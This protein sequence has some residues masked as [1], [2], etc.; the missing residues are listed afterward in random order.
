MRRFRTRLKPTRGFQYFAGRAVRLTHTDLQIFFPDLPAAFDGYRILQLSDLHLDHIDETAAAAARVIAGIE[1]D[2][3]VI[4]GDFRDSAR[5]PLDDVMAQLDRVVSATRAVDGVLGVLGNHDSVAMVEPIEALGVRLLLNETIDLYRG[6]ERI[7]V[8]GLDDVHMF[9]TSAA[10]EVLASVP[11]G[12][13]VALVHS[14]EIADRAAARHRLYLTGHTHG[15]QVCLPGGRPIFTSLRRPYRRFAR[16]LWNHGRMV[17][18]TSRGIGAAGLPIR[19][20]CRAEIVR[21]IL[22]KG[23]PR[24]VLDGRER[25][26]KIG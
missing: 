16:G 24:V 5:A 4:T 11:D 12:F 8:T 7:S 17:G 2:L 26:L 25:R 6:G 15:G 1:A 22:R 14:P 21:A 19:L 3:C 20:N 9:H 18:Y 13:A 23:P 10:E